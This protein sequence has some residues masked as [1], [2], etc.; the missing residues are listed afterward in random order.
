MSFLAGSGIEEVGEDP[1]VDLMTSARRQLQETDAALSR[2]S[3][4]ADQPGGFNAQPRKSQLKPQAD[5]LFLAQGRNRLHRH[6]VIVEVADN[7][8][9]GLIQ[10]DVSQRTQFMAIMNARLP[11][12]KRY[13]LHAL[14]QKMAWTR[15]DCQILV[16]RRVRRQ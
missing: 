2:R 4:P 9:V 8:A 7:A 5:A 6:T 10:S 16:S 11:R 12:G 1:L 14:C 3:G 13:Y 15:I